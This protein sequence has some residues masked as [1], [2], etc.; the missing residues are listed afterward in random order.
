MATPKQVVAN[1]RN[2]L[3]GGVKSEDGKKKIRLNA[4]KHGFFSKLVNEYD[5]ISYKDFANEIYA[6]FC[7]ANV[8]ESQ[9]VEI[10]LSN[11][12]A[13]RRI[14]FFESELISN[15]MEGSVNGDENI[16]FEF[17]RSSYQDKFRGAITDEL[18]KI[19]RYKISSF[20]MPRIQVRSAT[21]NGV[22]V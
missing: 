21:A 14:C 6:S 5:K 3:K 22:L 7:P 10:I 19:N 15:E 2:A 11:L 8:Y 12:L 18:I 17:G 13:Y 4:S 20:N 9:L 16:S 1:R